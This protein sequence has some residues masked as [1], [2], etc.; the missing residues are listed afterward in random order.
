VIKNRKQEINTYRFV[1]M[2]KNFCFNISV[3]SF[4]NNTIYNNKTIRLV[5]YYNN[6]IPYIYLNHNYICGTLIKLVIELSV[7]HGFTK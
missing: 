2:F 4:T 3:N 6:M 7:K 1:K 5:A